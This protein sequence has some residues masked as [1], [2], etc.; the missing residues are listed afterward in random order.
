MVRSNL[1]LNRIR[2]LCRYLS[3]RVIICSDGKKSFRSFEGARFDIILGTTSVWFWLIID[4]FWLT[5]SLISFLV[6]N[7][8]KLSQPANPYHVYHLNTGQSEYTLCHGLLWCCFFLLVTADATPTATLGIMLISVYFKEISIFID[9]SLI[10]HWVCA[11][12]CDCAHI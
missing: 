7:L 1:L 11:C 2:L 6:C 4:S 8:R 3:K 5:V 12:A 10:E 9:T